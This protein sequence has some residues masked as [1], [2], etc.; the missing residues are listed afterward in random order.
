MIEESI[1]FI[2]VEMSVNRGLTSFSFA[3]DGGGI[4]NGFEKGLMSEEGKSSKETRNYLNEAPAA[5]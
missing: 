5:N 2:W 3:I 4:V 1:H